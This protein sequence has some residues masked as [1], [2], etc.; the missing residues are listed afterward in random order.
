MTKLTL[1]QWFLKN[2]YLPTI[3]LV[4]IFIIFTLLLFGFSQSLNVKSRNLS[5]DQ[6]TQN[7]SLALTQKNRPQIETIL[8]TLKRLKDI[9]DVGIC[10][11]ENLILGGRSVE[12]ICT[13]NERFILTTILNGTNN[14]TLK[15]IFNN[16]Y[17]SVPFIA[18]SCAMILTLILIIFILKY[19]KSKYEKELLAVLININDNTDE[20]SIVEIQQM[21]EQLI[22]AK[23]IE[24][25]LEKE[26]AI[27]GL[28][29]QVYHDIRSPLAV[30][31]YLI[32][33]N[34]NEDALMAKRAINKIQTI[35]NDLLSQSKKNKSSTNVE[36][37]VNFSLFLKDAILEKRTEY[38]QHPAIFINLQ[39]DKITEYDFIKLNFIEFSRVISNLINNSAEAMGHRGTIHITLSKYEHQLHLTILD[40]GGGID[41]AILNQIGTQNFTTKEYGNGLGVH[42]ALNTVNQQGGRMHFANKKNGLEIV[43]QLPIYRSEILTETNPSC[44]IAILI[45]NDELIRL[46]WSKSAQK[47][48][49]ILYAYK[50][51]ELF[52][53]HRKE[54]HFPKDI[55]LYIDSEL[56]DN[57]KGEDLAIQLSAEGFSQIHL[58]TGHEKANFENLKF[59][60]SIIGKNPPF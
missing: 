56:D 37:D 54:L 4:V 27:N 25:E 21:T 17:T 35:A 20:I 53:E 46:I 12:N 55:N 10:M 6:F 14:Y 52:L 48:G 39:I 18:F 16:P 15:I 58:C 44:P 31:T 50:N 7:L 40:E 30:L 9:E 33:N 1:N 22:K 29:L 32:E 34:L 47:K 2:L 23:N 43:I 3:G 42:H 5:I 59:I 36:K 24:F 38:K 13:S 57:I 19:F 45:D 28:S 41:N 49:I 11:R 60:K 51:F 26:K 8:K